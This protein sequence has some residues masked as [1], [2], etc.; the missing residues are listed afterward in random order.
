MDIDNTIGNV[1]VASP[2]R[3]LYFHC[4]SMVHGER[5][6]QILD[7][8]DRR[9]FVPWVVVPR[10]DMLID[11]LADR[12]I[13]VTVAGICRN[14]HHRSNSALMLPGEVNRGRQIIGKVAPHIVHVNST[15]IELVFAGVA[16]RLANVPVVWHVPEVRQKNERSETVAKL[17]RGCAAR[18]I[19]VSRSASRWLGHPLNGEMVLIPNGIDTGIFAPERKPARE[20]AKRLGLSR[21]V[22]AVG[23]LGLIV[24]VK[25]VKDFV[26]AAAV[27]L[28]S[29]DAQFVVATDKQTHHTTT[30]RDLRRL[31]KELGIG[32]RIRFADPDVEPADMLPCLDIAVANTVS[33]S[34]AHVLWQVAASGIPLIAIRVDGV[35]QEDLIGKGCMATGPGDIDGLAGAI[36]TLVDDPDRA[37]R[38]GSAGRAHVIEHFSANRI[39][40][41]IQ[42]VYDDVLSQNTCGHEHATD[43][44]S[45]R[46]AAGPAVHTVVLDATEPAAS[47]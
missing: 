9:R 2:R 12:N 23:H 19:P 17:I 20:V 26:R 11:D 45:D 34:S 31:A 40:D 39:V 35:R 38:L 18:L 4:R 6:L 27:V 28:R 14:R 43:T 32:R 5:L 13:P 3:V 30:V 47:V 25:R 8:L 36:L 29:V 1:R 16:A 46:A 22:P 21:N 10:D 37:A 15:S 7:R 24:P 44:R 41:R 42:T 33:Q